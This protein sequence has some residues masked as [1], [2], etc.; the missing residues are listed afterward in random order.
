MKHKKVKIL[1]VVIFQLNFRD[2]M[3]VCSHSYKKKYP[4]DKSSVG[5]EDEFLLTPL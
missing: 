5:V 3:T 2:S 4:Q 1:R